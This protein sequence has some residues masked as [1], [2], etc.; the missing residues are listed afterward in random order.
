MR[1]C[2]RC[3]KCISLCPMKNISLENGN[4]VS[5]GKCTMCYRCVNFCPTQAITLLGK[6]VYEQCHIEKYL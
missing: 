1:K 4:T 5:G 2:I 3:G 6:R